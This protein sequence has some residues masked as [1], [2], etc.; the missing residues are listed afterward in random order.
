MAVC[1]PWDPM[2]PVPFYWS[3]PFYRSF[4]AIALELDLSPFYRSRIGPVPLLSVLAKDTDRHPRNRP[5][6]VVLFIGPYET[7]PLLS[8]I[9]FYSLELDLSLFSR[10]CPS[11]L[12]RPSFLGPAFIAFHEAISTSLIAVRI[13]ERLGDDGLATASA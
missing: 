10:S 13:P 1:A 6:S 9:H 2:G 11:F 12:G 4:I 5:L 8:R 3:V 7:C